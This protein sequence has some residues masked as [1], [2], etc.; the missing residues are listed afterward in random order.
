MQSLSTKQ[1]ILYLITG[2]AGILAVGFLPLLF[3][4]LYEE[5]RLPITFIGY[6]FTVELLGVGLGTTLC[7]RVYGNDLNVSKMALTLLLLA[8][9]N[10][11]SIYASDTVHLL[12]RLFAGITGGLIVGW[13]IKVILRSQRPTQVAAWYMT[14]QTIMQFIVAVIIAE[15]LI[16]EYGSTG[17]FIAIG[18]F[19]AITLIVVPFMTKLDLDLEPK[20]SD[21]S[22][23]GQILWMGLASIFFMMASLVCI[24]T[25][26][27]IHVISLNIPE[28]LARNT[29]PIIIGGQVVGGTL[30]LMLANTLSYRLVIPVSVAATIAV[31]LGLLSSTDAGIVLPLY[32]GVGFLWMF[33]SPFFVGWLVDVDPTRRTAEL[34]AAAQLAGIACG[35]LVAGVVGGNLSHAV[36]FSVA[37]ATGA[38][39]L[40]SLTSRLR[41]TSLG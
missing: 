31:L 23:P 5:G 37:A 35:P 27:E 1:V 38:I 25:Y 19:V 3:T 39:V 40:Y 13:T 32:A 41:K 10:V 17:G 24:V 30:A 6:A 18:I 9:I 2:I 15:A 8:A 21:A 26:S 7:R 22:Q 16:P 14:T 33:L 4:E 11:L 29:F 36:S 28:E 20:G 12:V 34:Y